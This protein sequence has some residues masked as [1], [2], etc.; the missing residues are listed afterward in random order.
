MSTIPELDVSVMKFTFGDLTPDTPVSPRTMD[1]VHSAT[2]KI[3]APFE[4][5]S[6]KE[7]TRLAL[8]V[9]PY[10]SLELIVHANAF[11]QYLWLLD[12]VAD[13]PKIGLPI[14]EQLL[15]ESLTVL[16]NP[17]TAVN[18]ICRLG[19]HLLSNL[20]DVE[21]KSYV[22][23]KCE[24]Y[25]RGVRKHLNS[26]GDI[27]TV[28]EY[29]KI[30]LDDGAVY[31]ALPFC[32]SDVDDF[33]PYSEYLHSDAGK[34]VLKLANM[35]ISYVND[36]YSYRKDVREGSNFNIVICH[37]SQHQTTITE[38]VQAL[39][40]ECNEQYRELARQQDELK[41]VQRLLR[42]CEGSLRWHR[43]AKRYRLP[44]AAEAAQ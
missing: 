12:D 16:S 32:F 39:V 8:E 36:L 1:D 4:F 34:Y 41:V 7:F 33:T 10:L 14:R 23:R 11:Q 35:N 5:T 43:E 44:K 22:S 26:A 9:Y 25:Y 31:A 18:P 30:R 17:S 15:D 38:S 19:V 20:T 13:D 28:E 37:M 42:W 3:L 21:M 27:L 6:S 29:L 40:E 24:R 2:A